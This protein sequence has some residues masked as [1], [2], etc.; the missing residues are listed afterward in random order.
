MKSSKSRK[1]EVPTDYVIAKFYEFGYKV[2]KN[3]HND[4]YN[5]CCP[6]CR[7]GKS[8]GRKKRCFYIPDNDLI[9]CHNCGWSGKPYFWI[10]EVS[11]I[12]HEQIAEEIK[13]GDF[14]IINVMDLN[15]KVEKKSEIPS[16]PE[17]SINLFDKTQTDYYK[18]NPIIKKALHYI[19]DRRLNSAINRPDAFFISLKDF[20]HKNRLVIPFKDG[21]GKIIYYQTRRILD[22]DS[23]NYL[24]KT[25]DRSVFGVDGV[26][27]KID[28]VFLL[29]G[30]LDACFV[31]N[32]LGLGG[33]TKGEQMFTKSQQYQ[34]EEFKF[35]EKIW[36]MDSQWIDKTAREK[37]LKLIEMGE[38]VF[39]WPEYDGKKFK[40]LNAICM[41]Y[42]MDE[43]PT[44]L[45]MKNSCKGLA[46]TVKMKMLY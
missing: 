37:T 42:E 39:I 1:I 45:I 12:S 31:R 2:T 13:D 30:P 44:E 27:D 28:K 14:G 11:G 33:V 40:D 41:A 17:D 15:E 46:A 25:S 21:H 24:S 6:I 10:R 19:K 5:C 43:Y 23:L 9:Y 18:D 20:L 16:L 22:D 36:V 8:W 4:T 34:M 26:S 38:K 3:N 7:E 29:E 32:G 35:Y